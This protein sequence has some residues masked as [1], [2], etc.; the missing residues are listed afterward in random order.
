VAPRRQARPTGPVISQIDRHGL[1]DD[2]AD[3]FLMQ[4]DA[5]CGGLNAK[6]SVDFDF[7]TAPDRKP[8]S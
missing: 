6:D 1:L 3:P 7:V 4:I 8:G 5:S 2:L